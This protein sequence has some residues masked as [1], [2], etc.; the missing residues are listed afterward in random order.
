MKSLPRNHFHS[1]QMPQWIGVMAIIIMIIGNNLRFL[2]QY[3][4]EWDAFQMLF[5][6]ISVF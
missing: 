2:L 6:N 3:I 1:E 5:T 4:E